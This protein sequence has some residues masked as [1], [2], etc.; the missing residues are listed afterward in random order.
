[1]SKIKELLAIHT[2]S[3]LAVL[4]G[5]SKTQIGFWSAGVNTPRKKC[6]V[7]AINALPLVR[8]AADITRTNW[9]L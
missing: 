6:Y 8:P 2:R 1:M 9:A 7:D 3:E 5:C 4:V